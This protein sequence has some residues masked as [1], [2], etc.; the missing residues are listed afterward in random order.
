MAAIPT[1]ATGWSELMDG[2]MVFAVYKMFDISLG[3]MGLFTL[4]MFVLYQFML[5]QKTGNITLMWIT[6]VLFTAM[7]ATSQ[8][9]P[10]STMF[11]LYI[12]LAIEFAAIFYLVFFS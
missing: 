11:V 3:N 9:I 7:F 12:I 8:F 6:G 2:N 10:G 1:N 5:Y 4:V